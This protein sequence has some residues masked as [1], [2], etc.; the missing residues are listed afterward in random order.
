MISKAASPMNTLELIRGC[1]A[2]K[3]LRTGMRT[4]ESASDLSS[5]GE[6]DFFSA[7]IST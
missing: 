2:K 3:S 1:L 5:L 6:S 7:M 4:F